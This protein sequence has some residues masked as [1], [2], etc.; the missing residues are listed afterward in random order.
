MDF[1]NLKTSFFLKFLIFNRYKQVFLIYSGYFI[2]NSST[3]AKQVF[4][5][6]LRY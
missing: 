3:G 2:F 1:K 4:L 5:I 6:D